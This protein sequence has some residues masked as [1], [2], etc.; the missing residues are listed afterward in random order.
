[1]TGEAADATMGGVNPI[2]RLRAVSSPP[3]VRDASTSLADAARGDEAAFGE[4]YELCA[5]MVYG[6]VR[7][8]VRDPSMSEE[9]TQEVFVELWRLAPR[10]D[11]SKGS[12][13]SWAATMAHRRAVDRV[14]SE[15]ARRTRDDREAN[16][17]RVVVDGPGDGVAAAVD[18]EVVAETL[19]SLSPS[20]RE[21]IT[22]AYYEGHSYREVAAL[23]D[24]P[25]GTVK[26]RIRDGL[27]KLRDHIGGG[28]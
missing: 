10:Y 20:Q 7:R 2:R 26:T 19:A 18:R 5:P 3:T 16:E 17:R 25:E 23:L 13:K 28:L 22:L 14:R 4:F 1:M 24:V 8:V 15:E 11:A 21:A 12:A 9:V 27:I 6:I